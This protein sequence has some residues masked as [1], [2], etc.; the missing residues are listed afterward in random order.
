MGGDD[1]LDRTL[2]LR[3]IGF[4]HLH[5]LLRGHHCRG[6]G[7][8]GLVLRRQHPNNRP[9]AA[10]GRASRKNRVEVRL[11]GA[12]ERPVDGPR[13]RL[14]G[15]QSDEIDQFLLGGDEVCMGIGQIRSRRC[16]C[17]VE[18]GSIVW[19][20]AGGDQ[21]QPFER[22]GA[23]AERREARRNLPIRL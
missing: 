22:L 6:T 19:I 10:R 3:V 11:V 12:G 8:E 15:R 16:Q 5:R 9:D 14:T 2:P 21:F 23:P 17:H 4:R 1:R 20:A 18:H 7:F 13:Q